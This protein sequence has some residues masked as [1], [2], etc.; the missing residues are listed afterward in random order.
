LPPKTRLSPAARGG[1]DTDFAAGRTRA[2]LEAMAEKMP[3][4]KV[5][6]ADDVARAVIACATHLTSSTGILVPVDEGRHL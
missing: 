4:G 3:L 5:T 1:V 6:T 2:Q